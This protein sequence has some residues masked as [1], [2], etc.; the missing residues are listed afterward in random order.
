MA[1]V[2]LTIRF[3]DGSRETIVAKG[4]SRRDT[5]ADLPETFHLLE[6][7]KAGKI[8][9]REKDGAIIS[10]HVLSTSDLDSMPADLEVGLPD[11]E[12]GPLAPAPKYTVPNCSNPNC[13]VPKSD[14]LHTKA[15]L[16]AC[17]K[18]VDKELNTRTELEAA[19][20]D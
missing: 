4:D 13:P 7:V 17:R 5:L 10:H 3:L 15:Q 11:M 18:A 1:R 8:S 12:D 20:G 9:I 19:G 14:M 16:Q 6:D 2:Q